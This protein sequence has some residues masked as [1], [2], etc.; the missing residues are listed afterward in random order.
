MRE[1]NINDKPMLGD[2]VVDRV[3]KFLYIIL[4]LRMAEPTIMSL[5]K[6]IQRDLLFFSLANLQTKHKLPKFFNE[7]NYKNK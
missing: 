3:V 6:S 4:S 2:T 7:N 1:R 5:V